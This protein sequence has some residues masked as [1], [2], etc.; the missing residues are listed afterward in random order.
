MLTIQTSQ[1]L[2]A[3]VRGARKQLGLTQAQLALAA[4]VGARFVV[5]LEA[6][7]PTVR[8]LHTLR[9]L[10][11]LGGEVQ[12]AGLPSAGGDHAA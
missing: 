8:L 12:L 11:T 4:G 5:E 10:A 9:V 7:K 1:Q 6:G 2:G 3:A